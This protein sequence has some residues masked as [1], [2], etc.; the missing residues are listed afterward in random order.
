MGLF[1]KL[2]EPSIKSEKMPISTRNETERYNEVELSFIAF[3]PANQ[4]L[5]ASI[6]I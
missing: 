4:E 6:L 3:L 1:S 5:Q 2:T